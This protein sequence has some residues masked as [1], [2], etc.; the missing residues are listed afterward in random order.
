ML[1]SNALEY[2]N[3]NLID[4]LLS[5][6]TKAITDIANVIDQRIPMK[7]SKINPGRF[8]PKPITA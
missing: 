3:C 8:K 2:Y 4:N 1:S 7:P 5:A 6:I